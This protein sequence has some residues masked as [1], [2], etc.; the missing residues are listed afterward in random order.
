MDLAY[1]VGQEHARRV[2]EVCA[3]GGH[4]AI[5][6]SAP[7]NGGATFRRAYEPLTA[8]LGCPGSW[9]AARPCPCGYRGDVVH[10]CTC[11]EREIVDYRNQHFAGEPADIVLEIARLPVEKLMRGLA[12]NANESTA[13][14]RARVDAARAIQE[15]RGALNGQ[16]SGT[17]VLTDSAFALNDSCRA[18]MTRAVERLGLSM[19]AYLGILRVSRTIADLAGAEH[20]EVPHL[21]EAVQ[22]R[23]GWESI[24][25]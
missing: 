6:F 19:A 14:V 10:H 15:G 1:I 17:A 3:A 21:A 2:M 8:G 7:G 5:A 22:Y 4:S 16:A 13:K 18:L 23:A 20:I 12:G 11:E 25:A 9:R 24:R